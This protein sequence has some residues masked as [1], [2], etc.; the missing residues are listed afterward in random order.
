MKIYAA[1]PEMWE[2][3]HLVHDTT[4]SYGQAVRFLP[5]RLVMRPR[6]GH[7]LLLHSLNLTTSPPSE[8]R[9]HRDLLDNVIAH[10]RFEEAS[11]AIRRVL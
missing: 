8:I 9:W 1:P 10:A 2:Q 4:Y 5:H 7:E 11:M 3:I 6:E